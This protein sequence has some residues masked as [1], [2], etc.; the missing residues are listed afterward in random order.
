MTHP[1]P[2]HPHPSGELTRRE[3]S[4]EVGRAAH[5]LQPGAETRWTPAENGLELPISGFYL[6]KLVGA[7]GW[8]AGAIDSKKIPVPEA[9]FG[10][11]AVQSPLGHTELRA[12]A[13]E[14]HRVEAADLD[15]ET[16]VTSWRGPDIIGSL[17]VDIDGGN[18]QQVP[19]SDWLKTELGNPGVRGGV[20][21]VTDPEEGVKYYAIGVNFKGEA[22]HWKV[23]G[24]VVELIPPEVP[25]VADPTHRQLPPA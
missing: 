22:D 24:G 5:D 20:I 8:G 4:D 17:R 6:G 3:L 13:L 19:I 1:R 7:D 18:S 16:G 10:L 14:G 12:E 11:E 23:E 25:S 15:A 21:R 2:E 9:G